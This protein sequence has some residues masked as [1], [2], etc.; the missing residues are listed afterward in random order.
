MMVNFLTTEKGKY[1]Y[2][3][4]AVPSMAFFIFEIKRNV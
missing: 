1:L 3:R 2:L 4:K